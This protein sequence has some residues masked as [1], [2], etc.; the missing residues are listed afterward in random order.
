MRFETTDYFEVSEHE[1]FEAVKES[2]HALNAYTQRAQGE[3]FDEDEYVDTPGTP[4]IVRAF[5][6]LYR[7]AVGRTRFEDNLDRYMSQA[8]TFTVIANELSDGFESKR[9]H[10]SDLMAGTLIQAYARYKVDH[11][12]RKA[13]SIL[14]E[15]VSTLFDDEDLDGMTILQLAYLARMKQQSV[16]NKLSSKTNYRLMRNSMGKHYL[17]IADAAEWLKQQIGFSEVRDQTKH[18]SATISVPVA[19]DGS[20]FTSK[21]KRRQGYQVGPKGNEFYVDDFHEA[22]E[23][24]KKMPTPYWR[25]PSRSSGVPGIVT[26]IRWEQRPRS[27]IFG[28]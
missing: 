17:N 18:D 21:L 13:S 10:G 9:A 26:G 4:I 27:E 7:Y 12:L 3:I 14:M 6:A 25:R 20:V 2:F 22:L 23:A 28:N 24:L 15:S 16:R 19:R 11:Y 5:E 1:L 8:I